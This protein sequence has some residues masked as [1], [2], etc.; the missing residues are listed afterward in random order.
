MPDPI[1]LKADVA[2]KFERRLEKRDELIEA[3]ESKKQEWE[4]AKQKVRAQIE[5]NRTYMEA[6]ADLHG[7]SAEDYVFESEEGVLRP[8]TDEEQAAREE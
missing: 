4:K 7:A 5:D 6:I 3:V 1:D 2:E 8:L